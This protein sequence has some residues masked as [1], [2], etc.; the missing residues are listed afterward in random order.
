MSVTF[1]SNWTGKQIGDFII[2]RPIGR[3]GMAM[4]YSARQRSVDRQVAL[5]IIE[6]HPGS[7]GEFLKRF[8]REAEVIAML[9]HIHILPVYGYGVL[10]GEAAYFAMRLLPHGTLADLLRKG[11]LPLDEAVDLF[12]QIAGGLAYIHSRG[13]IHRDLKPSNILLDENGNAFLTDFG[14]AQLVDTTLSL[15]EM[16]SHIAGSPAY[17]APEVIHGEPA[18][19][20]S[21]IYSLG[22]ILYQMV[23]GRLPF[24]SAEGKIPALLYQHMHE[25]P[26]PPRQVNPALPPA[27]ESVILRALNKAPEER[28]ASA[29]E[30]DFE[31]RSAA[32]SRHAISARLPRIT[33]TMRPIQRVIHLRRAFYLLLPITAILIA[34]IAGILV[35][36]SRTLPSMNVQS[37]A[38]AV[39]ADVSLSDAEVSLARDRLAPNGFIAYIPCVLDDSFQ[40]TVANSLRELAGGYQ[41]PLHIYDSEGD[42]AR[43]MAMVEQ[44]RVEGAKAFILC[45]LGEPLLDDTIQSLEEAE[46][47]L[48]LAQNY[49]TP[50]GVKIEMDD[51]ALGREQGV[52]A[53]QILQSE[54]N[55]RGTVALFTF[56]D[57]SAGQTRAQGMVAGL[58]Q[59]APQAQVLEPMNAYTRSQARQIVDDLIAKGTHIDTILT[60][61][62]DAALGAVD[63]LEAANI[64]PQDIFIISADNRQPETDFIRDAYS[65]H[66]IIDP[67]ENAQLLLSGIV[68]TLAGSPVAEYLMLGRGPLVTAGSG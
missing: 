62:D 38:R 27:V 40:A 56:L 10:E 8:T 16:S 60:I 1:T 22:V 32:Q 55:G 2:E 68:K 61:T 26:P 18:T 12:T 51:E 7:D 41:L 45:P 49:N 39:L 25:K 66:N 28:F 3:G 58:R 50:Y 48:V 14:L 46:L 31:L 6:L 24:D 29:E 47:P 4:V 13:V 67:T 17:I 37:G 34:V 52:Y 44:A 65:L 15:D 21:D 57:T 11:P 63:A 9:E 36:R 33:L 35:S 53:G 20:L 59:A 43:E 54:R 64:S 5:K 23:C 19:H 30:M 42:P